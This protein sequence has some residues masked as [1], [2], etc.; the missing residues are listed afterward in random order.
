MKA[1]I[2]IGPISFLSILL[3]C[4]FALGACGASNKAKRHVMN[5]PAKF[6]TPTLGQLKLRLPVLM[7][8]TSTVLPAGFKNLVIRS[9]N[10][11]HSEIYIGT[12]DNFQDSM[13]TYISKGILSDFIKTFDGFFSELVNVV[14]TQNYPKLQKIMD[15]HSAVSAKKYLRDNPSVYQFNFA[16][17][18]HMY[19][20][21]NNPKYVAEIYYLKGAIS[22]AD[23][24]AIVSGIK[25]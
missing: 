19:I 5:S 10:G 17:E 11:N 20:V 15:V 25:D 22:D 2:C 3:L 16:K 4:G 13:A 12:L 23:A 7:A 24:D 14:G 9:Q 1:K 21:F 6:F 8:Q 18:K